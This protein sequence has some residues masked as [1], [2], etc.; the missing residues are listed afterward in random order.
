MTPPADLV[1]RTA[2]PDDAAALTDLALRSKA[3]WGYE[4]ALM[5]AFTE[6]LTI[7][8][9]R[10]GERI[11]VAERA[12]ALAGYAELAGGPPKIE[13]LGLFV[14]PTQQGHGIGRV[15]FADAAQRARALG[16]TTLYW[17]ADPFAE[18]I[19]VRLGG[20]TVGLEPSGS[21]PGRFLP[22]M[23]LDLA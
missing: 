23:V 13:L 11:V 12:G 18:E 19:Y 15:L 8:A 6:E 2:R 1:L 22:R 16:A 17:D 4:E 20:H 7:P 3:S 9:T 10:C 21:V 5:S 14:E